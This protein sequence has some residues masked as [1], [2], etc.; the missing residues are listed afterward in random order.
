MDVARAD[1]VDTELDRIIS[2][3]ASQDRRQDPDELEASYA[4]SVRRYN[5]TRAA[6]NR[7]AWSAYHQEQ[8]ERLRRT[9]EDLIALHEARAAALCEEVPRG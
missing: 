4:E 8:A 2:R 7:A 5:A 9:L 3:R 6:E 1:T